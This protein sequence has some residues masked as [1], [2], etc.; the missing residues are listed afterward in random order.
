M[1]LKVQLIGGCNNLTAI[2]H[3]VSGTFETHSA[4]QNLDQSITFYHNTLVLKLAHIYAIRNVD[5]FC[6][7]QKT[8]R[9]LGLWKTFVGSL[10]TGLL[11]CVSGLYFDNVYR[12]RA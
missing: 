12:A 4:V 6:A 11:F 3:K 5:I 2:S 1:T 10:Y 7:G 8:D 9:T